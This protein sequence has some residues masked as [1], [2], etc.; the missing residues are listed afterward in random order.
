MT[1]MLSL[2]LVCIETLL[3]CVMLETNWIQTGSVESV[4]HIYFLYMLSLSGWIVTVNRMWLFSWAAVGVAVGRQ[5]QQPV[6]L[7]IRTSCWLA[8]VKGSH[9]DWTTAVVMWLWTTW[10]AVKRMWGNEFYTDFCFLSPKQRLDACSSWT[11]S[12]LWRGT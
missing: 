7:I 10:P 3:M 11:V 9:F 5:R 1:V 2:C 6:A 8:D 4:S 12:L